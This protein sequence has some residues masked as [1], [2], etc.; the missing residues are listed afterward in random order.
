MK[1]YFGKELE[2]IQKGAI[3]FTTENDELL[4]GVSGSGK[5]TYCERSIY[6]GPL[7]FTG[8]S[9]EKLGYGIQDFS[10]S[11]ISCDDVGGPIGDTLYLYEGM[12]DYRK[13]SWICGNGI[14]YFLKDGKPDAFFAGYFNG[15]TCVGDYNGPDI[16]SILNPSFKGTRRLNSL[17]PKQA[18]IQRLSEK[19]LEQCSID[20]LF[21][22]DSYFDNLNSY[23]DND[24]NT[25][26]EYYKGNNNAFNAGIG[27]WRFIDFIP[28]IDKLVFSGNPANMIVNLGFNDI[29]SGRN[30]ETT[31]KDMNDFLAPILTKIPDIQIYLL[32]VSHFSAF[33]HFRKEE[34]KY[35]EE[36][37]NRFQD[38]NNI[39]IIDSAS[40]F[41]EIKNSNLDFN[42]YIEP[43]LIH[44]N[45]KGYE[46]WMPYILKRV[47]G[48]RF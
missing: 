3:I 21:I 45:E 42:D 18:K 38:N 36:I 24:G 26:F 16:N 10:S 30:A 6:T 46:K 34:N 2:S 41:E 15:T 40:V 22:G 8:K 48:Y 14:F 4:K 43:D 32:T 5:V 12:F 7:V 44:P 17:Y 47:K 9:F 29:H 23:K 1:T 35:N 25:L 33:P 19:L 27:G 39:T 11:T 37:M 28:Y 20:Y 13:T 31:L